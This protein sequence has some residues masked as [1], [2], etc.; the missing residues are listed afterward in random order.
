MF[1]VARRFRSG[2]NKWLRNTMVALYNAHWA[3]NGMN[4]PPRTSFST[5]TT[6]GTANRA[7]F[8][9][10]NGLVGMAVRGTNFGDRIVLLGGSGVPMILRSMSDGCWVVVGACY[11]HGVMDGKL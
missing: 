4:G 2:N 9:A 5:R 8:V 11:L 3:A 7:M 6:S 10:Q 1:N